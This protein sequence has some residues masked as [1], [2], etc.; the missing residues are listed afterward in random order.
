[1]VQGL[2]EHERMRQMVNKFHNPEVVEKLMSGSLQLGGER[3]DAVV[4]FTDVRGFT[5]MSETTNPE[6]VVKILNRYFTRMVDIVLKH[7]GI[8]DKYVGDAIMAVWGIPQPS[9]FDKENAIYACLDMRRALAKLN[10]EFEAEGLP[11]LHIGMGLNYGPVIAGIIGSEE[12]MEYTLIGDTVNTASRIEG[13]TKEYGVDSLV[14]QAIVESMQGKFA[15]EPVGTVQ[16]KGKQ[17]LVQVSKIIGT[18][19]TKS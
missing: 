12:R 4:L 3:L 7:G 18:L 19:K 14:S 15:F 9:A 10:K 2:S 16:V 13:L 17:D 8:V 5:S 1:M 6:V 11:S